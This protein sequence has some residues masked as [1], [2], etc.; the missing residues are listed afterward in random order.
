MLAK[1]CG[2]HK[3]L[4]I[5]HLK[6]VKIFQYEQRFFL[7]KSTFVFCE[8]SYSLLLCFPAR[9]FCCVRL[10]HREWTQSTCPAAAWRSCLL[11]SSTARTSPTSISKTTS[12]PHTEV[13]Q[14]SP[15]VF[16]LS[17]HI[18]LILAA[19]V[20]CVD[21][22]A[23]GAG[24]WKLHFVLFVILPSVCGNVPW[25]LFSAPMCNWGSGLDQMTHDVCVGHFV[26]LMIKNKL[27]C[28]L[29]ISHMTPG[30]E[31]FC[32]VFF[33]RSS[34]WSVTLNAWVIFILHK[35]EFGYFL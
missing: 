29:D 30:S 27:R 23:G 33:L 4:N 8:H 11:S 21:T 6:S 17:A 22:A 24:R 14:H 19:L 10:H 13:S 1:S 34:K 9:P 18:H 15:G 28:R 2:I 26:V 25:L 12:C 20:L 5:S 16:L 3:W 32:P 35:K 31:D 7:T